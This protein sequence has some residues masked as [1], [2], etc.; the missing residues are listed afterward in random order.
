MTRQDDDS[1]TFAWDGDDVAAITYALLREADS[2]YVTFE[3]FPENAG[4]RLVIGPYTLETVGTIPDREILLAKRV[5][6]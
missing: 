6:E 1:I 2:R 5:D 4:D 3:K